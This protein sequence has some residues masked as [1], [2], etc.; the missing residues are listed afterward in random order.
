ML[1]QPLPSA[2]KKPLAAAA[3][4]LGLYS[5][6]RACSAMFFRSSLHSRFTVATTF[7]NGCA[8]MDGA[9]NDAP[10]AAGW[11]AAAAQDPRAAACTP[12]SRDDGAL[13]IGRQQHCRHGW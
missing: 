13:I 9:A 2:A 10:Q 6:L 3:P 11:Q 7:C 5:A 8:G 1:A 4:T 12:R